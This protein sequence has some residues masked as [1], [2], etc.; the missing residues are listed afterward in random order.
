MIVEHYR[1]GKTLAYVLPAIMHI[2]H[3]KSSKQ[4]DG[5]VA[6]ILAPTRE[7]AQQIQQVLLQFG[8]PSGIK[9][10]C[11]CGG[12][13]KIYQMADINKGFDIAIAT[14]GRLI[15]LLDGKTLDLHRCSYLVLDEGK[16]FHFATPY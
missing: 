4:G 10:L 13:G 5:P 12:V 11:L 9:S 15:D 1:S 7:L 14:P 3:Q 16:N 2:F 6:L 8:G